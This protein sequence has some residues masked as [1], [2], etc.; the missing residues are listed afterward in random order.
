M[1][2]HAA[3]K[4]SSS[5]DILS[6]SESEDDSDVAREEEELRRLEAEIAEIERETAKMGLGI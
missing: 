3:L 6:L 4:G 5:S 1:S 2:H